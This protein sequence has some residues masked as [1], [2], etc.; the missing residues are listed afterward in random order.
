MFAIPIL[1]GLGG[2]AAVK[3]LNRGHK[4]PPDMVQLKKEEETLRKLVKELER[5]AKRDSAKLDELDELKQQAE[6]LKVI[7]PPRLRS[8]LSCRGT[9][10]GA[11]LHGIRL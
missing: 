11:W 2:A 3:L 1:T 8:C 6:Q 9:L 5:D 10:D 4:L 7:E